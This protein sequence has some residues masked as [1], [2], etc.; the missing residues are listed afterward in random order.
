MA[1][2][3]TLQPNK[4]GKIVSGLDLQTPIPQDVI[5]QLVQDV[6]KHQLLIFKN[7]GIL[8]PERQ[9]GNEKFKV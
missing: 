1:L 8:P 3:Y 2:R 4:L 5:K 7:Q 9:I 6:A